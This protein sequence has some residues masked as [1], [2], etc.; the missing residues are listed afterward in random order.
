M[1]P[2]EFVKPFEPLVKAARSVT[3]SFQDCNRFCDTV[4]EAVLVDFGMPETS[5]VIHDLAHRQPRLF[6][7]I[8]DFLHQRGVKQEYP[9][10][11]ELTETVTDLNK[12][13]EIAT[14]CLLDIDAELAKFIREV[15]GME[16]CGAIARGAEA[17]QQENSAS[18][19]K[20]LT[21]WKLWNSGSMNAAAYDL[22]V[23]SYFGR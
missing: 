10:T 2:D 19:E 23:H 4:K 18:F 16:G 20:L 11:E 15:D 7:Q 9:P 17:L 8:G 6:D 22:W 13:F 5:G 12:A 3:A 14:S 21:A 1:T